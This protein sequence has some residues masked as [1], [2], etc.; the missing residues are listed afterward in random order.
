MCWRNG[1]QMWCYKELIGL[2]D[3]YPHQGIGTLIRSNWMCYQEV[4]PGW[5]KWCTVE[6]KPLKAF[7]CPDK[8]SSSPSFFLPLPC[9]SSSPLSCPPPHMYE[10]PFS[11]LTAMKWAAFLFQAPPPWCFC[12]VT[13]NDGVRGN[14]LMLVKLWAQRYLNSFSLIFCHS[15]GKM[16]QHSTQY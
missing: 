12:L 13:K 5:R 8:A 1:P 3:H 11:F 15:K 14:I 10:L 4:R 2:W 9:S 16:D 7:L 6:K